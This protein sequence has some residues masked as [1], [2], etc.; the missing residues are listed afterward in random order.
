MS[1]SFNLLDEPWIRL[2]DRSG[3]HEASLRE[4]LAGA[5]DVIALAGELPTQDAAVLR[6][7]LAVLHRSFAGDPRR[8]VD[9]WRELWETPTLPMTAV[10]EY[11]A[12]VTHRFDLLDPEAPF[13]Q[14]GGITAGKSS[15][16]IKLIADVPDGQ[17]YFTTRAGRDLES[18]SFAEAA[19]WLVHAQAFDPSGIKT[20]VLGDPRV[21]GGKGYPIGTGWS[22]R[23]GLVILEGANLRETLLLNLVLGVP[24]SDPE[25]DL[26]VW[27]RSPLGPGVERRHPEPLGP[28]DIMTWPVRRILLHREGDRVVDVLLGNGDRIEPRNRQDVET[29]TAWRRSANQEKVHG[30]TVYM[31]R[32]HDPSRALWRGLA[33][34]LVERPDAG[35]IKN[36]APAVLPPTNIAW[37]ARLRLAGAIHAEHPIRLHGVGMSYGTQDASIEAVF[38]DTL[39]MRAAVASDPVL[40]SLALEAAHQGEDAALLIGALAANLAAASGRDVEGPRE[41]AREDAF[42][43]L[44][45]RYAAW[46]A[47]LTPADA[48]A[49]AERRSQ[50]EVWATVHP[51]G[52][53]L[54]A[55]AGEAAWVGRA[56]RGRHIDSSLA[57]AWFR[58]NLRKALPLTAKDGSTQP[59]EESHE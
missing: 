24:E 29:M 23:C 38:D 50:E 7:L 53:Q 12:T 46:L 35:A 58:S 57:W 26:P 11:L 4:V 39:T 32:P 56:V 48:D 40:R 30:G 52:Q 51:L 43:Q 5:H 27:E 55:D 45:Q 33:G 8:P 16:L 54:V 36:A 42:H 47:A 41:A 22:G 44:G 2:R 9:V 3:L 28:A 10:D 20:G 21:K 31:P 15:G 14:A 18:L 19:R 37:L 17:P 25:A 34:I 59:E 1:E 13:F 49:G 6:L